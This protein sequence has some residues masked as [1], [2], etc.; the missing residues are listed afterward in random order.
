M[1]CRK[2]FRI[3][4]CR[5]LFS[6]TRRNRRCPKCGGA[7]NY[8]NIR[9]VSMDNQAM[10]FYKKH[11]DKF[12]EDCFLHLNSKNMEKLEKILNNQKS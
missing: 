8:S 7:I 9:F 6:K 5:Y 4:K 11:K 10:Y 3:F 2:I 12:N 1:K